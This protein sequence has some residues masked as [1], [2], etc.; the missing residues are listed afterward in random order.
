MDRRT[1]YDLLIDAAPDMLSELQSC[2][3]YLADLAESLIGA[4]LEIT[5]G[6]TLTRLQSVRSVI[7]QAIGEK[8]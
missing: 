1:A 3:T 7:A 2:E 8:P 5:G 6:R 4:G